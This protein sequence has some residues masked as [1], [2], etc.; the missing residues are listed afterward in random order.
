MRRDRWRAASATGNTWVRKCSS[1][2]AR[3]GFLSSPPS[4]STTPAAASAGRS[5]S[6]RCCWSL[7]ELRH[8][9]ADA[10]ELLG[11]RE[12]VRALRRDA[13][14]HLALQ[15]GDAHHEEFVEVVGRDRQEAHPLEQRMVLVGGLFQHAP[16][17][18]QPGQFAV[19]ETLRARAQ[20][21]SGLATALLRFRRRARFPQPGAIACARSAI[22]K[23]RLKD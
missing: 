20:A 17:E 5:S 19:D 8:R 10:G 12:P 6:Q 11:R 13:L 21:R 14:A 2:Q 18:M 15:A 16:I 1:N 9:L 7:R 3:S 4:T 22:W 23:S